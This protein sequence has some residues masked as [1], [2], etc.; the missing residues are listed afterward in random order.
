MPTGNHR[1]DLFFRSAHCARACTGLF[2][3]IDEQI[4]ITGQI[5][6]VIAT[7]M[8]TFIFIFAAWT[9]FVCGDLVS[10]GIA[11]ARH[12]K[13]TSIA[14]DVTRLVVRLFSYVVI[15]ILFFHFADRLGIPVGAVFAS[16]G[17]AGFAVAMAAKDSLSNL[18]GGLTIFMDR[19]F[20]R[21]DYIVLDNN[22]RGEVMQIGIRSTRIKTRDD[23]MISIPNAAI[24]NAKVVNQSSPEPMF[25]VRIKIGV[26]YGSDI[27]QVE[28]ILVQ[29]VL[30]NPLAARD[31][32]PRVRFRAFGNSSLDFELLCWARRPH[33]RGR[34]V[35][36]LNTS[37]YN[38][39]NE[40]GI[41]IPFAQQDVYIR[42][43]P[44]GGRKQGSIE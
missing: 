38:A 44:E 5:L 40:V 8:K 19:P 10:E 35:H 31:P 12:L 3:F 17:I 23:V 9:V 14:A 34:L 42:D 26:A 30:S 39:F 36:G 27:K 2:Y 29:Q 41:E 20:Q 33:D 1:P 6:I 18:F 15:F 4:N 22:E 25:R 16:A 43:L 21:G 24:T 37:I 28:D 11:N 32:E 7:V 13:A